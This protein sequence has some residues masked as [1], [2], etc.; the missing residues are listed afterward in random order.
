MNNREFSQSDLI[1]K[2][3]CEEAGVKATKR[4]ASKFRNGKGRA[5]SKKN[6]AKRLVEQNQ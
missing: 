4:Q 6:L 5:F 3:A 2:K 1:F